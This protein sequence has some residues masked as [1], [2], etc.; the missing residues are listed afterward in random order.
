MF[1]VGFFLNGLYQ[2]LIFTFYGGPGYF[3][4][5]VAAG[6]YGYL[7]FVFLPAIEEEFYI[8]IGC[9]E[10]SKVLEFK[11]GDDAVAFYGVFRPGE[12][13]SDLEEGFPFLD[14][15]H[16]AE[17][18]GFAFIVNLDGNRYFDPVFGFDLFGRC[19][20]DLYGFWG[21]GGY[22]EGFGVDG[23]LP[24][25]VWVGG[26]WSDFEGLWFFGVVAYVYGEVCGVVRVDFLYGVGAVD[27]KEFFGENEGEY[28]DYDEYDDEEEGGE[29]EWCVFAECVVEADGFGGWFEGVVDGFKEGETEYVDGDGD[30]CGG[31]SA[32]AIGWDGEGDGVWVECGVAGY[33]E[34]DGYVFGS[35]AAAAF[36]VAVGV[37]VLDVP[38][39][40]GGDG[41]AVGVGVVIGAGV[42][43]FDDEVEGAIGA[44]FDLFGFGV[45]GYGD[46]V[47]D[48]VFW[49]F[50]EGVVGGAAG[51]S[52][53]IDSHGEEV[54][55]GF[56]G[57]GGGC[58]GEYGGF[59]GSLVNGEC[60]WLDGYVPVTCF[61]DD[62][63]IEGDCICVFAADGKVIDNRFSGDDLFI[64][65]VW[66]D[67]HV[68]VV[69]FCKCELEGWGVRSWAKE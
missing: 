55:V 49:Y 38:V 36:E 69:G 39:V 3:D 56:F 15:D 45:G 52:F 14:R 12:G 25:D 24:F 29:T 34:D 19:D 48:G 28:D 57:V 23:G 30:G 46:L 5:S 51:F 53:S 9:G 66:I 42:V 33:G 6:G 18:N 35:G 67:G 21:V 20:G 44:F 1:N 63:G 43:V 26:V 50:G 41:D 64:G 31:G 58:E 10:G 11:R 40:F 17:A 8:D 13:V 32:A 59:G 61:F 62:A 27:G 7:D 65:G 4:I 60:F 16:G 2:D 68:D 54:A 47:V 22:G 37:D